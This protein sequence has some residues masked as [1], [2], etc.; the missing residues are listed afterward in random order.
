[1]AGGLLLPRQWLSWRMT[2][3]ACAVSIIA[4]LSNKYVLPIL[5]LLASIFAPA[6]GTHNIGSL[7]VPTALGRVLQ[8]VPTSA[9]AGA[10][11]VLTGLGFGEIEAVKCTLSR[12]VVDSELAR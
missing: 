7:A 5:L 4:R 6:C 1:M 3:V 2:E 11:V 10:S 8:V 12:S 9:K